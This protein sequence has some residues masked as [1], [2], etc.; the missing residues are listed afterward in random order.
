MKKLLALPLAFCLS[1][2]NA[3]NLQVQ[4]L[5]VTG[6]ATLAT[7]PVTTGNC[8]NILAYGGAANG[9]TDNSTAFAN[10]AS[11]S[12]AAQ[13]CV[14]FPPGTYYFSASAAYAITT[15]PG[16]ITLRGA[17]ADVTVLTFGNSSTSGILVNYKD[18]FSSAHVRDMTIA[19][20]SASASRG[21]DLEQLAT[22]V[23]SGQG[24][25][26]LSDI[27]NVTFRGSDGYSATNY[28]ATGVN[29]GGVSNI[30][31][32]NDV[33]LGPEGA[34]HGYGISLQGA[35][36][37]A[38][39]LPVVYNII[40]CNFE[41]LSIGLFYGGVAQGVSVSSSNFTSNT[42]GIYA[43]GSSSTA[44]DQLSVTGSQF[45]NSG[46]SI[47]AETEL[48]AVSITNN[49]FLVQ[50]NTAAI[51]LNLTDNFTISGNNFMPATQPAI[52]QNA[53]QI[54]SYAGGAG[55][56]TGNTFDGVDAGIILN[57]GAKYVNVQS[58]AYSPSVGTRVS[59]LGSN[60]TVSGGSP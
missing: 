52:N 41:Q 14:Y 32:V 58:N 43:H 20:G 3:Q 2:V 31:F 28:W 26:A 5:T 11:A 7:P 39:I 24:Q 47:D 25:F 56:I 19:A 15:S 8:S 38:S 13:A 27:T 53:I 49:F 29:I 51:N 42:W 36:N 1:T 17:G 21:I 12:S 9:T 6:T 46:F 59:D 18:K 30:N 16:S 10:A 45:N 37:N 50:N 4:N 55:S 33:F 54:N 48:Q 22:S 40:G 34:G 35:P 60:N 57:A 44:L 23:A